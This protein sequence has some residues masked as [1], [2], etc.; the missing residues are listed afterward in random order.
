M[1]IMTTVANSTAIDVEY[2]LIVENPSEQRVR[3]EIY[4]NLPEVLKKKEYFDML[5][6]VWTPGSYKIREFP[7][8]VFDVKVTD[9][10]G[11][12]LRFERKN[13]FQWRIYIEN[14][15]NSIK[16]SYYVYTN[17]FTVRTSYLSDDFG[18]F[19]GTTL[20][21]YNKAFQTKPSILRVT[22][23]KGWRTFVSLPAYKKVSRSFVAENFDELVDSPILIC[24]KYEIETF[25]I[26]GKPHHLVLVN[27]PPLYTPQKMRNDLKRIVLEQAA[28][29]G[30]IPDYKQYYFFLIFDSAD[31]VGGGL[32]HRA[33]NVSMLTIKGFQERYRSYLSLEAHEFFHTWNIKR[34]YPNTLSP[35][36]DYTKENYSKV[37]WFV[38]GATSYYSTLTLIRSK[39]INMKTFLDNLAEKITQFEHMPGKKRHSLTMSSFLTWI[40]LYMRDTDPNFINTSVSYYLKGEIV[41]LLLDLEIRRQT[42]SQKSLDTVFEYLYHEYAKKKQPYREDQLYS[43]IQHVTKANLS[44]FFQ[45]YVEGTEDIPYND[46]FQYVGLQLREKNKDIKTPYLGV[47]LSS[48]SANCPQVVHVIEDSPAFRS[49]LMPND[50]IIALNNYKVTAKTFDNKLKLFKPGEVIKVTIFRRNL[51]KEIRIKTTTPPKDFELITIRRASPEQTLARK[52]WLSSRQKRG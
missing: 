40:K 45:K 9:E 49:G 4:F 27:R 28:I 2:H 22:P 23:P 12:F 38:E 46:F 36:F 34:I 16:I 14:N 37:L 19:N 17:D 15:V 25:N 50:E 51:L 42:K 8:H 31:K 47:K 30:E 7:R 1:I 48:N 44:E 43:I 21:M 32:E 33:S 29:F 24:R 6:P 39:L 41:N 18:I 11:V 3:V 35:P 20:F 10:S 13:K 26:S 5:M 52:L